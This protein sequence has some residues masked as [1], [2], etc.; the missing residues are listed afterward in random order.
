MS[1]KETYIIVELRTLPIH[2]KKIMINECEGNTYISLLG[3]SPRLA[4]SP[5]ATPIVN[6]IVSHGYHPC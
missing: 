1:V 3:H 5:H 4:F 2:P 6:H